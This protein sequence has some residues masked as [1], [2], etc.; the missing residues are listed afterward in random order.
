MYGILLNERAGR[1]KRKMRNQTLYRIWVRAAITNQ[2]ENIHVAYESRHIILSTIATV[3]LTIRL[4]A[5]R[6]MFGVQHI[7]RDGTT[8]ENNRFVRPFQLSWLA[9]G[10]VTLQPIS[11]HINTSFPISVNL[12][13][14]E[15]IS[16]P[17][18]GRT[19]PSHTQFTF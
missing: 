15:R 6:A 18:R 9:C 4:D 7:L 10:W 17:P 19:V 1:K 12:S 11:I 5:R 13:G 8:S 3:R 16:F 14:L 2:L